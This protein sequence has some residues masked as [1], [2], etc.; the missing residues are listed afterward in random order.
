MNQTLNKKI[1]IKEERYSLRFIKFGKNKKLMNLNQQKKIL[2]QFIKN[3]EVILQYE[4]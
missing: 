1:S 4:V 3:K 2:N